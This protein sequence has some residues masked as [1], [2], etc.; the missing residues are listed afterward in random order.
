MSLLLKLDNCRSSIDLIDYIDITYQIK[1]KILW[2]LND[3]L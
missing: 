2:K 3:K 1:N